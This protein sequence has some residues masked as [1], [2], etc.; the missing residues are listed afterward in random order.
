MQTLVTSPSGPN[1]D[2]RD[3]CPSFIAV[4]PGV[5]KPLPIPSGDASAATGIADG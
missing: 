3:P 2:V 5:R 4:A 1:P